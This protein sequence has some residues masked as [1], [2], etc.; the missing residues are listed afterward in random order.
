MTPVS[1]CCERG[2]NF[3]HWV[4]NLLISLLL[5]NLK[6]AKMLQCLPQKPFSSPLIIWL[7]LFCIF[8][9]SSDSFLWCSSHNEAIGQ[10]WFVR[11]TTILAVLLSIPLLMDPSVEFALFITVTN[12]IN[13]TRFFS[14]LDLRMGHNLLS[15]LIE[16]HL[17][18]S[19]IFC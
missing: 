5:Q 1:Y 7:V 6:K 12:N 8:S 9:S 15:V 16:L 19:S 17:T 14:W 13:F 11:S 18:F 3:S 2:E 10:L 4:L